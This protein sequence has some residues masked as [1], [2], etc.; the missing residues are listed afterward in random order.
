MDETT[1]KRI[2]DE[3]GYYV[4]KVSNGWSEEAAEFYMRDKLEGCPAEAIEQAVRDA[5]ER[6]EDVRSRL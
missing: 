1:Q 2:D 6:I 5:R 4:A 3:V